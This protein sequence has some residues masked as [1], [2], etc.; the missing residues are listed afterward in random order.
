MSDV[1]PTARALTLADLA[2]VMPI[3][4]REARRALRR[5]GLPSQEREDLEQDLL[6]DLLRRM[7]SFDGARGSLEAFATLC[8]RHHALRQA[9]R[10][11]RERVRHHHLGFDDPTGLDDGAGGALAL[12]ETLPESEGLAAWWG[13]PIDPHVALERQWDVAQASDALTEDELRL[14]GALA[15]QPATEAFHGASLSRAT[16]YRRVR[17]MRL[18][19]LAAGIAEA[20]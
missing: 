9:E 10:L 3:V 4:Q 11:S 1:P 7:P 18:R 8:C 16:G 14:A 5:R 17:E 12:A 6:V 19:L 13:Q 2:R 20:A 15:V